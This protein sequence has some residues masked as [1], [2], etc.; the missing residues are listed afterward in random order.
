MQNQHY[1]N[2]LYQNPERVNAQIKVHQEEIARL[3]ALLAEQ[4][5]RQATRQQQ[6]F[7][8][9]YQRNFNY[10]PEVSVHHPQMMRPNYISVE[11]TQIPVGR[12]VR[13]GE[14]DYPR[15]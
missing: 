15:L 13:Q 2:Q 12:P 1:S 14:F 8:H 11:E 6:N 10:Y 7:N 4:Q 5:Q 9:G 3:R